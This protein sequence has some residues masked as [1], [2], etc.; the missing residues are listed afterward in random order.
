MGGAAGGKDSTDGERRSS[1]IVPPQPMWK[2]RPAGTAYAIGDTAKVDKNVD[3]DLWEDPA[4][5]QPPPQTP[6]GETNAEPQSVSSPAPA[7]VPATW[8]AGVKIEIDPGG[9]R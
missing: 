2:T 8:T 5:V 9:T 7:A 6:H 1:G 4:G 3:R